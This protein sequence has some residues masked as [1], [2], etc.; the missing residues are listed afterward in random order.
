MLD[1][2]LENKLY[3]NVLHHGVQRF[4]HPNEKNE[5]IVKHLMP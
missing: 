1:V 5:N 2:Y 4:L 3:P